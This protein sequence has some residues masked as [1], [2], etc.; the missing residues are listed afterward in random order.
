MGKTFEHQ[1]PYSSVRPFCRHCSKPIEKHHRGG[2]RDSHFFCL[3]L[4]DKTYE[5]EQ[6]QRA[7]SQDAL[8][9]IL[10]CIICMYCPCLLMGRGQGTPAR[11]KHCHKKEHMHYPPPKT[12]KGNRRKYC[13]PQP[14][15]DLP[16]D[17]CWG[18][19]TMFAFRLPDNLVENGQMVQGIG[20]ICFMIFLAVWLP[21]TIVC[22]QHKNNEAGAILIL[23]PPIVILCSIARNYSIWNQ[24]KQQLESFLAEQAEQASLPISPE[25][26]AN[27]NPSSFRP[28]QALNP[29]P[30]G[31]SIQVIPAPLQMMGGMPGQIPP[32][33][34]L[35]PPSN[36]QAGWREAFDPRTGRRYYQNE[37]T[38]TT[39]WERPW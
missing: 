15:S 18:P 39:Q 4:D 32:A 23:S 17:V 8:S 9:S 2:P 12:Q 20:F 6:T 7:A 3:S 14:N 28:L 19:K 29:V 38:K 22:F 35:P 16:F 5:P 11:C 33:M 34:G 13:K 37:I 10:T 24:E 26:Q 1:Y 21:V 36:I 27:N 31:P 30:A 25:V